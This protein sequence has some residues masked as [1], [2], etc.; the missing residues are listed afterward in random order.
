MNRCISI[1][2]TYQTPHFEDM[3]NVEKYL[4]GYENYIVIDV[5]SNSPVRIDLSFH[6]SFIQKISKY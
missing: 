6:D 1:L 2:T 4:T 3:L 5:A